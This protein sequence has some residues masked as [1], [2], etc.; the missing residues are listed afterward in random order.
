MK[1]TNYTVSFIMTDVLQQQG[2]FRSDSRV[3]GHVVLVCT[4]CRGRFSARIN[5]SIIK[6]NSGRF[7]K[8]YY[9][10]FFKPEATHVYSGACFF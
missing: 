2:L 4:D 7:R 5:T 1:L 10:I 6:Q 8:K 3:F 9:C